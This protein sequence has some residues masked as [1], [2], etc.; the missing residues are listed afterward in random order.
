MDLL[1]L[2][3]IDK[4]M[5]IIYALIVVMAI[6]LIIIFTL[7]AKNKKKN[8]DD[9]DIVIK[10][11]TPLEQYQQTNNLQAKVEQ[12]I[13]QLE[14]D[15]VKTKE[16]EEIKEEP[17]E[18][19]EIIEE[20]TIKYVEDK[21]IEEQQEEAQKELDKAALSLIDDKKEEDTLTNF[22][23]EQEENAIISYNELV[24]VSENLYESNEKTQYE[25]EGNEPIT[26]E[27]LREKFSDSPKE[28][29]KAEPNSELVSTIDKIIN[30]SKKETQNESINLN[31]QKENI[32]RPKVKLDDF[33]LE[34]ETK[35]ET[36]FKSSP[37]ISPVF[38]IE[39][40]K[41]IKE[42]TELELEQTADLEKL[43]A[44]IRKTNQ[45]LQVLKELQ[46]KLD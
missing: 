29:L 23:I 45:F 5:I 46:K 21:T 1:N 6:L 37:I 16:I 35:K 4:D 44:E 18:E 32:E 17:K 3:S 40:E 27:Q 41:T 19:T 22:E 15:Q 26:I 11:T 39:K 2:L 28:E 42:Q 33:V 31:K 13:E 30:D 20:S 8:L 14:Q 36:K 25:D 7:D 38:G 9:E 10:G 34:K 43:D 24:K 12:K